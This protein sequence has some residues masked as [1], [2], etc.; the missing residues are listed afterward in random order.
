M[1]EVIIGLNWLDII[2]LIIALISLAGNL[3]QYMQIK[4]LKEELR[5]PVYNSIVG[6]FMDIKTKMRNATMRQC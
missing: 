2:F 1:K 5:R 3:Y 4:N 6:L